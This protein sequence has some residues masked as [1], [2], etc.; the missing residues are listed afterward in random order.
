M[1]RDSGVTS[2]QCISACYKFSCLHP[3]TLQ[4]QFVLYLC[5]IVLFSTLRTQRIDESVIAAMVFFGEN[6]STIRQASIP[7]RT[8]Q[9]ANDFI[10]HSWCDSVALPK[11]RD[12]NT[13]PGPPHTYTIELF[14]CHFSVT[15]KGYQIGLQ[16]QRHQENK[17]MLELRTRLYSKPC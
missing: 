9:Y 1:S 3:I 2:A 13:R 6:S 14:R 12:G 7:R 11:S 8:P 4:C 10:L 15:L 5:V 17:Y 16:L